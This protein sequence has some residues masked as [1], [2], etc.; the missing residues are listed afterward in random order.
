MT[1]SVMNCVHRVLLLVIG[2]RSRGSHVAEPLIDGTLDSLIVVLLLKFRDSRLQLSTSAYDSLVRI[3]IVEIFQ[4]DMNFCVNAELIV[5]L[6]FPQFIDA[7][8][9]LEERL[10]LRRVTLSERL[11]RLM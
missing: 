4:A 9:L 2:A 8:R 10:N 1:G 11:L 6:N 5:L 7:D 3:G